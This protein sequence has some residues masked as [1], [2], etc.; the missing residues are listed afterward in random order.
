MSNIKFYI[1]TPSIFWMFFLL[2]ISFLSFGIFLIYQFLQEP[3]FKNLVAWI[4]AF[5]TF[6]GVILTGL[7][8]IKNSI[9]QH[10]ISYWLNVR[11]SDSDTTS[12]KIINNFGKR[13]PILNK[14]I[15]DSDHFQQEIEPH[16]L[17]ILNQLEFCAV[18]LRTGDFDEFILKN[19]MAGILEKNFEFSQSYITE[20][21]KKN[22]RVSLFEHIEVLNSRWSSQPNIYI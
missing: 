21:R 15:I 16:L 14:E 6:I 7:F 22:N 9:K 5:I 3:A 10:T 1:K 19:A 18:C 12:L 8:S 13:T 2:A 11:T 20:L 17:H 4:T